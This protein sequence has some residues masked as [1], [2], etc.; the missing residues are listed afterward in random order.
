MQPFPGRGTALERPSETGE[1]GVP[2]TPRVV[3]PGGL[4]CWDQGRRPGV[5]IQLTPSKT[6]APSAWQGRAVR[7]AVCKPPTPTPRRVW[8]EF[9]LGPHRPAAADPLPLEVGRP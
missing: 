5:Q 4:S 2:P 8:A 7:G 9:V 3:V 1:G 6:P